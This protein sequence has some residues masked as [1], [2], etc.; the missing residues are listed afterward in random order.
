MVVMDIVWTS[1]SLDASSG[2]LLYT[3]DGI[4]HSSIRPLYGGVGVPSRIPLFVDGFGE[5]IDR[6][7]D[8]AF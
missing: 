2:C 7:S 3:V 4:G 6:A 8:S 1:R 5:T